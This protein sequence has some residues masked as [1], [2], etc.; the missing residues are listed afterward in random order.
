VG[1]A[2]ED[3]EPPIGDYEET[4]VN[5]NQVL[6]CQRKTYGH[7]IYWFDLGRRV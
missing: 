2:T 3:G 6:P 4:A 5:I 1:G 7:K